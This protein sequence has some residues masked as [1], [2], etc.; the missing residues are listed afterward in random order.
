MVALVLADW[1]VITGLGAAWLGWQ[2]VAVGGLPRALRPRD[3]PPAPRGSPE[4]F[5]R[6][7]LDQYCF[8]G[9]TLGL[10]GLVLAIGG[11]LA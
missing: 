5:L 10:G 1:L 11:A 4:A 3:E 6:F 2:I 9:L 8:I 7:W